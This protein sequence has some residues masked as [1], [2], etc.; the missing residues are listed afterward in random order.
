MFRQVSGTSHDLNGVY[1]EDNVTGWAVGGSGT[2]LKTRDGG[3]LWQQR[4]SGVSETLHAV[5][6]SDILTGW[7]LGENGTI[8]TT[9]NGGITWAEQ[10]TGTGLALLGVDFRE[11]PDRLG[12]RRGW[13]DTGHGATDRG[14]MDPSAGPDDLGPGGGGLRGR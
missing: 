14:L 1:F 12:G 4:S 10:D 2:I 3:R 6:F 5:M 7:A 9:S 8:V 11:R 13:H